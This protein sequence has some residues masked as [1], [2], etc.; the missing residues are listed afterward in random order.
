[1]MLTLLEEEAIRDFLEE[2]WQRVYPKKADPANIEL[3]YKHTINNVLPIKV[4]DEMYELL[5]QMVPQF[6]NLSNVA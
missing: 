4:R 1:M 3:I 6:E 5:L 2:H